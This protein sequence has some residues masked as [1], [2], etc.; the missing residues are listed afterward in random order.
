MQGLRVRVLCSCCRM[1][2][3]LQGFQF[4]LHCNRQP[5]NPYFPPSQQTYGSFRGY[6]CHRHERVGMIVVACDQETGMWPAWSNLSNYFG[7]TCIQLLRGRRRA[8]HL[9]AP[10]DQLG[11]FRSSNLHGCGSSAG[12]QAVMCWG[13]MMTRYDNIQTIFTKTCRTSGPCMQL[14]FTKVLCSERSES[15]TWREQ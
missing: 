2:V 15:H 10:F 13:R 4:H 12:P 9:L 11:G 1:T 7:N 8:P 14:N 3:T 5:N 6:C